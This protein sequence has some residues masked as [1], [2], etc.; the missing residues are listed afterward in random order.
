M[1]NRILNPV[2][3]PVQIEVVQKESGRGELGMIQRVLSH[4]REAFRYGR[5]AIMRQK[6]L[7]IRLGTSAAG[8]PSP[9]RSPYENPAF[10][11][12]DRGPPADSRAR[13]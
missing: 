7:N 3:Q 11:Q 10:V 5:H 2:V 8:P 4:G 9:G 1:T 13:G 12:C 6:R